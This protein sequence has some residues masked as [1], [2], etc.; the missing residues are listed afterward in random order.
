MAGDR[1]TCLVGSYALRGVHDLGQKV[2]FYQL[3]QLDEALVHISGAVDN[4]KAFAVYHF[5]DGGLDELGES[6][7]L[8]KESLRAQT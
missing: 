2:V 7:N 3:K 5:I 8:S 4:L 6:L 1:P